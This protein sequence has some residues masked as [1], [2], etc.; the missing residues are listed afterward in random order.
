MKKQIVLSMMVASGLLLADGEIDKAVDEFDPV[1]KE[2][3]KK[4][5]SKKKLKHFHEPFCMCN[6]SPL[7]S[8]HEYDG[9]VHGYARLHHVFAGEDNGFDKETGSTLGFELKYDTHLTHELYGGVEYYGVTDTG[10]TDEDESIAYGQFMSKDKNPNQKYGDAWG[11]HIAYIDEDFKATLARS[12]FDSPLTKMQITHVPNLFEY[13]RVDTKASDVD[14]SLS[15]ITRIAYGSR[16]AADF[17][18]IG[19][20]TGTAGMVASPFNN[21]ERGRYYSISDVVGND[22]VDG[23]VVLGAKKTFEHFRLEAWDFY[24][25]DTLNNLYVEMEYPFYD[26]KGYAAGLHAQYLNQSVDDKYDENYGGSLYGVKLS[27][28]MKKLKV[29]V[30]YNKKDDKGGFLN[31]SGANP[32]YTSSIFSRNEYRS[33]VSAV[34]VSAMYPLAKGLKVI[35]SYA[36]YGQSDMTLNRGATKSALESQTDAEET[37]IILVYKPMKNLTL[38]LFN[39]NRTSEFDTATSDRTQ[40]HTRFIANYAF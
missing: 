2:T 12:Q 7:F 18:L 13:A 35:A 34:K 32:G 38:K 26:N 9:K 11:A 22:S 29:N 30:A 24:V 4:K 23:V 19:E 31:P 27:T 10:L 16:S 3:V 15:Y 33:G 14:L 28:K 8:E 40:N 20:K 5:A 25:N 37:N 17:G 36:D 6:K 1:V 39:A 21:I